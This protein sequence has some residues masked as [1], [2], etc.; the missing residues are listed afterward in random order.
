MMKEQLLCV[1]LLGAGVLVPSAGLGDEIQF[2][3]GEH[4]RLDGKDFHD[5]RC[6]IFSRYGDSVFVRNESGRACGICFTPS[7]LWHLDK[8]AVA[9]LVP[10]WQIF[11]LDV[12]DTL[13]RIKGWPASTQQL[14]KDWDACIA[15]HGTAEDVA[16]I[17]C[18]LLSLRPM[19]PTSPE[20]T[21]T[22]D[23][24]GKDAIWQIQA[25][26]ENA[27]AIDLDGATDGVTGAPKCPLKIQLVRGSNVQ[28]TGWSGAIGLG[29]AGRIV[30]GNK[31]LNAISFE[32]RGMALQWTVEAT[33][34]D[35]RGTG[36][37]PHHGS[38]GIVAAVVG[39]AD[40][41][42]T[43]VNS[44]V[45]NAWE[46]GRCGNGCTWE[47][48]SDGRGG[49]FGVLSGV[50]SIAG[51][52]P[53]H[54]VDTKLDGFKA[55]SGW[56]LAPIGNGNTFAVR[57][58][59]CD[60]TYTAPISRHFENSNAVV[61]GLLTN[62][63]GEVTNPA[64][65]PMFLEKWTVDGIGN[66]NTFKVLARDRA[67]IFAMIANG[68]STHGFGGG[69]DWTIGNIG[70]DNL[71]SST[72]GIASLFAM[73][74]RL[75]GES[76]G[77]LFNRWTVGNIGSR[78]TFEAISTGGTASTGVREPTATTSNS[79]SASV[80]GHVSDI[81]AKIVNSMLSDWSFGKIGDGNS[82]SASAAYAFGKE[83]IDSSSASIFGLVTK[84]GNEQIILAAA[85]QQASVAQ[86][87]KSILESVP[88]V[89]PIPPAPALAL[90]TDS[91]SIEKVRFLNCWKFS[92]IGNFNSFVSK[93][94][95]ASSIFALFDN[96]GYGKNEEFFYNW[97]IGTIGNGNRF[98]A[99]SENLN[100]SDAHTSIF[101]LMS[102][103]GH[104]EVS[105]FT[106]YS[107]IIVVP[108]EN[109]GRFF[110][111]WRIGYIGDHNTFSSEAI[112]GGNVNAGVFGVAANCLSRGTSFSN[113]SIAGFGNWN[114]LTASAH[115]A[116]D[117]MSS[118][119]NSSIFGLWTDTMEDNGSKFSSWQFGKFGNDNIFSAEADG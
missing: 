36:E 68:G 29:S 109:P 47:V 37:V 21:L 5:G 99:I 84:F 65:R 58:S 69:N 74:S 15:Q 95:G 55:L 66:A 94:E 88:A 119:V 25:L 18:D 57:P 33:A 117:E 63:S 61:A 32:P 43:E 20:R 14:A 16:K 86:A 28:V 41:C 118:C 46:I 107:C 45:L 44:S 111:D 34:K 9:A 87:L 13:D 104:G 91:E 50:R 90:T 48:F 22:I 4:I 56:H 62:L 54:V 42:L 100:K 19:L 40:L 78:N 52:S 72:A 17:V 98:I 39:A 103:L 76:M 70:D 2:S 85:P 113:W 112:G 6:R 105:V 49:I 8:D 96:V 35:H 106:T 114:T 79:S 26:E 7:W 75:G 31:Y 97:E 82:F 110:S 38:R 89:E 3:T 80:F 67:S 71:F 93:S 12:P 101:G 83:L 81:D 77:E 51:S 53:D 92:E 64:A 30:Y 10:D 73:A 108:E 27:T 1:C 59:R 102:A 23:G 115:M 24:G 116:G 60:P 11:A